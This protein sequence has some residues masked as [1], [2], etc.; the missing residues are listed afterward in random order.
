MKQW[1][2]IFDGHI[3]VDAPDAQAGINKAIE[4]LNESGAYFTINDVEEY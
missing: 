4:I 2:V 1:D 3:V